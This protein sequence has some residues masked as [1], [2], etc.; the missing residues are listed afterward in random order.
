MPSHQDP[1]H[2]QEAEKFIEDTRRAWHLREELELCTA[3]NEQ[4]FTCSDLLLVVRRSIAFGLEM[5]L[6]ANINKFV[7]HQEPYSLEEIDDMEGRQKREAH[8]Y[9]SGYGVA[10]SAKNSAISE[11][12]KSLV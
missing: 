4:H 1:R 6:E 3:G 7:E 9:N 8:C 11:I 10:L 2:A 12:L 5:A